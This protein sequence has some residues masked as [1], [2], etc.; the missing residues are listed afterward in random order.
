MTIYTNAIADTTADII[1]LAFL[2]QIRTG[3]NGDPVL[4][5]ANQ[6]SDCS[7]FAGTHLLDCPT[8]GNDIKTC[9][10]V[11]GKKILLSI[12]GATY[13]DGGFTSPSQAVAAAELLVRTFGPTSAN[14]ARR[15]DNDTLNVNVTNWNASAHGGWQKAN[16]AGGATNI[17]FP[18]HNETNATATGDWHPPTG[19]QPTPSGQPAT[20]SLAPRAVTV[21]RPFGDA[22]LDGFNLDFESS[23]QFLVPFAR[24]LRA[25]LNANQRKRTYLTAAPTCPDSNIQ[26]DV[27]LNSDVFLD[28]VFVQFYNN[29]CGLQSFN[30]GASRQLDFN[31]NAWNAW[32]ASKK[33]KIYLGVPGGTTAANDGYL[34]AAELAPVIKYSRHFSHFG[35]VAVWDASQ[36]AANSGFLRSVRLAMKS[37]R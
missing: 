5:F 9:Q 16:L 28:A 37:R 36:A 17:T 6:Q 32:A 22:V 14:L 21:H 30:P 8:I 27:L 15:Q 34:S 1:P 13:T 18:Q 7:V 26:D 11:Y 19:I 35:G 23:V 29:P 2:T 24:A 31:F 10:N 25:R 4:N 3:D 12:G 33:T 20:E